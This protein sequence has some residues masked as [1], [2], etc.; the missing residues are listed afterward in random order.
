M[1]DPELDDGEEGSLLGVFVAIPIALIALVVFAW[2]LSGSP[3]S[4]SDVDKSAGCAKQG[5]VTVNAP[6]AVDS[7]A[8]EIEQAQA[9]SLCPTSKEISRE[10]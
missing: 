2:A 9:K 1:T 4:F 8:N 6:S 5:L 7:R 10:K 3:S